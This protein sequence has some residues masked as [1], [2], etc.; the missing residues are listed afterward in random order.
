L[1]GKF[2]RI[3]IYGSPGSGKST[4]AVQIGQ[5]LNI[6]YFHLDDLF[7]GPRWESLD[8]ESFRRNILKIVKTDNWIIDGNYRKIRPLILSKATWGIILDLPAHLVI[9]RV[10]VRTAGRKNKL[11]R[12]IGK[13]TPL[14]IKVRKS[15]DGES[16]IDALKEFIP[17]ALK[18]KKGRLITIQSDIEKYLGENQSFIFHHQE[19][20]D[21]FLTKLHRKQDL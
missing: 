9:W 5:I 2:N 4:L 7:H 1:H 6:P 20:I 15:G 19:E 14:P 11:I 21:D 16:V 13:I 8:D 10:I 3:A 18:F 17:K 12:K